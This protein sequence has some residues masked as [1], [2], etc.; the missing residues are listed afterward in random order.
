MKLLVEQTLYYVLEFN[1]K[2]FKI[3]TFDK[4]RIC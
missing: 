1:K 2:A 3:K 4:F